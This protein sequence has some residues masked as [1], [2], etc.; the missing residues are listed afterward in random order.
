[1]TPAVR[2]VLTTLGSI[3]S[4]NAK[5]GTARSAVE[6]QIANAKAEVTRLREFAGSARSV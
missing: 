1:M 3:D 6:A 4:R 5:G 2:E